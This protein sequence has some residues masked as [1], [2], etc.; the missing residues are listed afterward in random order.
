M[1]Q[2]NVDI[3]VET[4]NTLIDN[5]IVDDIRIDDISNDSN[6]QE[7]T[8]NFVED[9][10]YS[11][12]H[13]DITTLRRVISNI[14]KSY[15]QLQFVSE[16][17][18][19]KTLVPFIHECKRTGQKISS[20]DHLYNNVIKPLCDL[21]LLEFEV[22]RPIFGLT[23][24]SP[25]P[26]TVGSFT[27][28]DLSLHQTLLENKFSSKISPTFQTACTASIQNTTLISYKVNARDD[29]KANELSEIKFDQVQNIFRF[30]TAFLQ[31]YLDVGITNY[32]QSNLRTLFIASRS[33]IKR[34]FKRSGSF[35]TIDLQDM[36]TELKQISLDPED[37]IKSLEDHHCC[38]MKECILTSIDLLGRARYDRDKP[39]AL[40]ESMM[41]VEALIQM[42]TQQ[43][44]NQSISAQICEYSAF[45]LSEKYEERLEIENSVKNF[46]RLRSKL[47]H[48]ISSTISKSDISAV[49]TFAESLIYLFLTKDSLKML[50]SKKDLKDYTQKLKFM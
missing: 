48:G 6:D 24:S 5:C 38:E 19:K 49:Y 31:D 46:Y 13:A 30:F 41:A 1:K 7:T 35:I 42:N 43:L 4:L 44:V 17:L 9:K 16:S 22:I 12:S 2:S 40:L 8:W 21:P 18:I 39:I 14:S 3:M 28:Y 47:A 29:E 15:S 23:L 37:L 25:T 36:F 50:K 27:F 45:L 34:Q 10:Q 33:G 11:F 32:Q 26:I 20:Y